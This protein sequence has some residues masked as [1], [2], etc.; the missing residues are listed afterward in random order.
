MIWWETLVLHRHSNDVAQSCKSGRSRHV[1]PGLIVL[2]G[3]GDLAVLDIQAGDVPE[4]V[5]NSQIGA[6]ER[7][8]VLPGPIE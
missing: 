7:H 8:I 3:D 4:A 6:F 5:S 2:V 1:F